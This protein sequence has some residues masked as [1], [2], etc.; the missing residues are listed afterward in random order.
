MDSNDNPKKITLLTAIIVGMNAM[1]GIGI[2]AIPTI[3]ADQ[4]GPAGILSCLFSIFLILCIGL[5]LARAAEIFPGAGWNYLYPSKWGGHKIGMIASSF[6]ILAVIAAMGFLTQQAGIWCSTFIPFIIPKYLGIIII[7][8]LMLFVIAGAQASSFVQYLIAGCVLIPLG[9]TAFYCWFN[10][11]SSL[12]TPFMPQGISSIF[13]A[14][15]SIVFAFG[16]FESIISLYAILDNPKKNIPRAFVFSIVGVGIIYIFFFYGILF[17][18]PNTF[19]V[20]GLNTTLFHVLK[21]YFPQAKILATFVLFG[22]VFGIIG[23]L[24][25]MIWSLSTLFTSVLKITKSKFVHNALD[26]NIW[27]NKVSVILTTVAIALTSLFIR[28]EALPPL[29]SLFIIS[30]YVLSIMALLFVRQ[31]WKS[32]HNIITVLGLITGFFMIYIAGLKVLD[33]LL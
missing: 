6:Y 4:V 8:I 27:N 31:E 9:S 18:I 23:T 24:H 10:F 19:F 14:V 2:A 3:L 26:K 5:S 32:G 17:A 33:V 30:T 1:I 15:P 16:G 25:S 21:G 13:H 22:A 11:D 20:G 29:T 12:V 28:G 7:F